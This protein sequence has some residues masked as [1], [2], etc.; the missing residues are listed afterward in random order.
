MH[1]PSSGTVNR[2]NPTANPQL[3]RV[4]AHSLERY[5]SVEKEMWTWALVSTISE[6]P[7]SYTKKADL[8]DILI[9][10]YIL[11]DTCFV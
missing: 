3:E 10:Q 2:M 8:I 1:I 4:W 7:V 6:I 5:P 9:V 11:V